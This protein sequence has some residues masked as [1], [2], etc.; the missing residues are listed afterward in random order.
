MNNVYCLI[1]EDTF[2]GG[3]PAVKGKKYEVDEATLKQLVRC[4]RAVPCD[5]PKNAGPS[6]A[7]AVEVEE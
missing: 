5:P 2:I 1:T 7:K 6:K 4:K 3:E